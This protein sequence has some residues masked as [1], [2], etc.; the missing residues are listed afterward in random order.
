MEENDHWLPGRYLVDSHID[1][2]AAHQPE[3]EKTDRNKVLGKWDNSLIFG[4][5][6]LILFF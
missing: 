2:H 4:I 6:W 5:W 1:P 3:Y